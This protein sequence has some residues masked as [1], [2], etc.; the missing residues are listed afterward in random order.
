MYKLNPSDD[1]Y[2]R[3]SADE[4]KFSDTSAGSIVISNLKSLSS[5]DEQLSEDEL[6]L[7]HS[8]S[9]LVHKLR[10]K[11]GFSISQLA[12]KLDVDESEL[13]NIES[14]SGYKPPLRT[15][16]QISNFYGLP[17]QALSMI[18]G[19]VKNINLQFKNDLVRYAANSDKFEKLTKEEK[20]QLN[21]IIKCIREFGEK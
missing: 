1:W 2:R 10:I 13:I 6:L 3:A 19:V 8:F 18:A 4:D 12:K 5:N 14:N 15:L 21:E 11:D 17:Y 9:I 7:K 16:M 20:E